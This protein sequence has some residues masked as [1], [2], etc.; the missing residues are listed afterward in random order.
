MVMLAKHLNRLQAPDSGGGVS[1]HNAAVPGAWESVPI[2][3][4]QAL[5][6]MRE[7]HNIGGCWHIIIGYTAGS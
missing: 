1:R 6:S 5:E 2:P 7:F 4:G 3:C